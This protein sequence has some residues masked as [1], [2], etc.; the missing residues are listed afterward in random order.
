MPKQPEEHSI[1]SASGSVRWFNCPGSV[2]ATKNYK[3]EESIYAAE[4]TVAH[5][6]IADEL[7]II[8]TGGGTVL[9]NREHT[10]SR[11]PFI[12]QSL[13]KKI[14]DTI[15]QGE[16]EIEVTEEMID[17]VFEFI[18]LVMD[19]SEV[20]CVLKIE[21]RVDL[22]KHN[23]YLFGT[24]DVVIIKPFEWIKVIDFKYGAGIKVDAYENTQLLYYLTCAWEGEDVA[25]G[26]AII[27]QPRKEDGTSR[28][29][30]THDEY[31]KFKYLLL[32]N[33]DE[34]MKKNAR[35]VAGYW[36]KKSFCPHFANCTASEALAQEIVKNDFKEPASPD[37]LSMNKI[38]SVL[39]KADFITAWMNAV[40]GRAKEL[41]LAGETVP[42]YKL[43]QGYKHRAWQ[44]PTSV[45]E[46]FAGKDIFD[47]PKLKSPAKLE[48]ILGKK[49]VED[50]HYKP[51]GEIKMVPENAKGEPL[52]I[53]HKADYDD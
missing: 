36:C 37:S 38:V 11:K 24:A 49:A 47:K 5:G 48:K 14:G 33:A 22:A 18:E 9:G 23:P 7:E 45:E 32:V 46:D 40:K 20:D 51:E 31:M 16:F 34:A 10:N 28:Y 27:C 53:N 52:Q 41:M 3:N 50:Y 1:L 25:Y 6:I 26:E 35:L 15:M 29:Q 17:A 13:E 2:E 44:S 39:D 21:E 19:E 30:V 4:G 42:G 8:F 12:R 43:V